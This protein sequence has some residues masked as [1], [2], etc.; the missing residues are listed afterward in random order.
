MG[1]CW[2]GVQGRRKSCRG[3]HREERRRRRVA[4]SGSEKFRTEESLDRRE[5]EQTF[6]HSTIGRRMGWG[7]NER[8]FAE[9]ESKPLTCEP[10]HLFAQ[11]IYA[12]C[13]PLNL[14]ERRPSPKPVSNWD[15][16]AIWRFAMGRCVPRTSITLP[17]LSIPSF[18]SFALFSRTSIGDWRGLRGISGGRPYANLSCSSFQ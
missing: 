10:E 7:F 13:V 16:H 18:V 11:S 2:V 5:L 14:T 3:R 8:R 12:L 4:R 15:S 6:I 1:L 9:L 17:R